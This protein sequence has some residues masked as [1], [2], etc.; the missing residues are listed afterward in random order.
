MGMRGWRRLLPVAAGVALLATV[1]TGCDWPAGT[2][3]VFPVFQSFD[4]AENVTYRTTTD[5]RGNSVTLQLDIY[6]PRGDTA[7]KRP[8]I[9]WMHGGFWV[10][11]NKQDMRAWAQDSARRGYVGVTVSYRLRDNINDF[12]AAAMDAYDDV[13][14]AAQWLEAHAAE[15]RIDPAAIIAGGYSAGAINS[16]NLVFLPPDRGPATSPVDGAISVA[17]MSFAP[18]RA[19]RD[20][21]VMFNGTTDTLVPYATASDNCNTSRNLGNVCEMNTYQGEGHGIGGAHRDEILAKSAHFVMDNILLPL[22]Y[23][24]QQMP[25]VAAA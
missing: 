19:G 25:V 4:S 1:T 16:M 24:A 8:A 12:S 21:I 18:I 17:G 7:T 5:F 3:Y 22:G 20:P 23:Q 13:A 6:Q 2:R 10:G 14:A 9:M 15:Y 11:G